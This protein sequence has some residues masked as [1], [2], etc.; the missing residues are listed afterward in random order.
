MYKISLTNENLLS[1]RMHH[2][3]AEV[4]LGTYLIR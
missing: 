2:A 3:I 1:A 4:R